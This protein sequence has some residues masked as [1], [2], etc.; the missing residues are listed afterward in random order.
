MPFVVLS[1]YALK[2][3]VCHVHYVN[4]PYA[5]I[6]TVIKMA[7]DENIEYVYKVNDKYRQIKVKGVRM[8]CVVMIN[9]F[10]KRKQ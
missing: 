7:C 4:K 1:N 2:T 10:R 9:Q 8:I 5:P 3:K 6:R